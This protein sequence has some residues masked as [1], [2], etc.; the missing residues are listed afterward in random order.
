[1]R[2][3]TT[4]NLLRW[5]AI[6]AVSLF[7]LW[8]SG[9]FIWASQRA[10]GGPL[11]DALGL[12]GVVK[13][14]LGLAAEAVIKP[15]LDPEH[16][17]VADL[18]VFAVT[19]PGGESVT[20][21]LEQPVAPVPESPSTIDLLSGSTK[22]PDVGCRSSSCG[23][24][25][26]NALAE[27][28]QSYDYVKTLDHTERMRLHYRLHAESGFEGVKGKIQRVGQGGGTGPIRRLIRR[29]RR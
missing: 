7:A 18:D 26:I 2:R 1:M 15:G 8:G 20:I 9:F 22:R 12:P 29:W 21:R 24:C 3:E 27:H 19:I 16:T 10:Y 14:P 4:K 11:S 17:R 28:G 5:V 13:G 6:A 25:V 23:M